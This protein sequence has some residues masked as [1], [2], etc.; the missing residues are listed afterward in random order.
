[1]KLWKVIKEA[2]LK[3]GKQVITENDAVLSFEDTVIYAE[4]FAERL[5]DFH[6]CAI[7]CSSEMA[8]G[9]AL[10]SCFAA[11]VTAMPLSHRYGSVHCKKILDTIHPDAIIMD[12]DGDLCVYHISDNTYT[13]PK[14]HPAL[15]MCTSGTTGKPKGVMLG[16]EGILTNAQDIAAYAHIGPKDRILIARPLYHCAVLTGEFL[17]SLL[18][19]VQIR[20]YSETFNPLKA[21]TLVR[22]YEITV[23]GGTPTL[24]GMMS[25]LKKESDVY[26]IRHIFVS[27]ECMGRETGLRIRKAFPKA[28]IYH[29][30]GLTEASPRVAYLPPESFGEFPDCVG[31]PLK[32]VEIRIADRDGNAIP[33]GEEGFLWVR[34]KNVMMGYY[35]DPVRTHTVLRD[36]WLFTGDNAVVNDAGFLKIKGRGDDLIIKAGMNIYP[37]EVESALRQDSRVRDVLVYGISSQEGTQ[38]GMK[39]SGDFPS[40][41]EVKR[42]CL[43]YLPVFQVPT[44]IEIVEDLPRNA[45]GKILRRTEAPAAEMT[46]KEGNHG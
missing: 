35:C 10:L 19:G 21:L 45:S 13:V 30:Y 7:L 20:F 42:M 22:Q 40:V 32:S 1:M 31:I 38:I 27:G 12:E 33:R 18:R 14:E 6:C 8:T 15:M 43:Q 39:I 37:A 11:G 28:K 3:H 23:F 16:E 29:V 25:R 46:K 34:G 9:M 17:L 44:K 4:W 2:M 26:N 41:G 36:G 5:R 24:L